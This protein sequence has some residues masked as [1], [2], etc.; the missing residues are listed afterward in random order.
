MDEEM[1]V[2]EEGVLFTI[3]GS[4][5]KT[6][7]HFVGETIP[8]DAIKKLDFS[9]DIWV[10]IYTPSDI[11]YGC[12]DYE[13]SCGDICSK[14]LKKTWVRYKEAKEEYPRLNRKQ[15]EKW[16]GQHGSIFECDED[17]D[18]LRINCCVTDDKNQ[19][20]KIYLKGKILIDDK[21][22]NVILVDSDGN[23]FIKYNMKNK[24]T[25]D[26]IDIIYCEI[27][28]IYKEKYQDLSIYLSSYKS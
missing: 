24:K 6:I 22:K 18:E 17:S 28:E 3:P 2:D 26:V 14:H 1:F 4:S 16:V 20:Y 8:L 15:I 10:I 7:I 23:E 19:K 25:E 12:L 21:I 5:K 27:Y 13:S 11:G 9:N